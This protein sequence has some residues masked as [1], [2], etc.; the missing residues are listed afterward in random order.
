MQY[1]S[2][3]GAAGYVST[4]GSSAPDAV[5]SLRCT[6]SST[7]KCSSL[8]ATRGAYDGV[9]LRKQLGCGLVQ[10]VGLGRHSLAFVA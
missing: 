10:A 8:P 4:P 3:V 5:P 2:V 6:K 7:R 1:V 9:V